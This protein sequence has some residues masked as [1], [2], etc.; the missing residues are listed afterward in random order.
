[1]TGS[2]NTAYTV[3]DIRDLLRY[4]HARAAFDAQHR[5]MIA[6]N[7][8]T[9]I[10]R[11]MNL[12]YWSA[13]NCP[14]PGR[15]R[16]EVANT[17]GV[18]RRLLRDSMAVLKKELDEQAL[19]YFVGEVAERH[20]CVVD[21]MWSLPIQEFGALMDGLPTPAPVT[22]PVAP[23]A[24]AHEPQ[25]P[26]AAQKE[27]KL[28][29]RQ[30]L[31]LTEMLAMNAVGSRKKTTRNG[32]VQRMDKKKTGADYAR[33]FGALKEANYTDSDAGPDGGVWLT[34][35]GKAKAEELKEENDQ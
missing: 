29:D 7:P 18:Y 21:Q 31:I 14:Q 15:L 30:K 33:D 19:L 2:P 17:F 13:I 11:G 24:E 1:M 12:N 8:V 35:K 6:M 23:S 22:P 20:G 4:R 34:G 3:N 9:D 25:T 5:S 10:S 27:P 26:S 28:S 32:V 16:E